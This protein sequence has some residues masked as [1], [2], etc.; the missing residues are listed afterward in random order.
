M[1]EPCRVSCS[2]TI[3]AMSNV[4]RYPPAM[5]LWLY[6][7]CGQG[8]IPLNEDPRATPPLAELSGRL[9]GAVPSNVSSGAV[10]AALGWKV[11]PQAV[12]DCTVST[13]DEPCSN[14]GAPGLIAEDVR[15]NAV[16]PNEFKIPLVSLPTQG[17]LM[18]V[19]GSKLAVADV[20][21]YV[22]A[23]GNGRLDQLDDDATS[24]VDIGLGMSAVSTKDS[25]TVYSIVFREGALSP[26]YYRSFAD[27]SCAVPPA[28]FSVLK[29]MTSVD[30]N[31]DAHLTC[32]VQTLELPIPVEM[33]PEGD[34]SI[35][36]RIVCKNSGDVKAY[37]PPAAAPLMSHSLK[38]ASPTRLWLNRNPA[39]ICKT[40][41]TKLIALKG[42]T[43]TPWDF[44]QERPA[45][46]PCD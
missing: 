15:V 25:G 11:L 40:A 18:G 42:S 35:N 27:P 8:V 3:N 19:A 32:T 24:P 46:W 5:L 13:A 1:N 22:D 28:G 10:R 31:G 17:A 39:A 2:T 21:I 26:I 33:A 23:N 29:R 37:P 34:E 41:N 38:C 7:G 6:V 20:F 44:T 43:P 30:E 4:R 12:I 36:E 45:W 9:P 16:F 14:L